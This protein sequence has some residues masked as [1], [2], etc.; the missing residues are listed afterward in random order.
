MPDWVA[1][2]SQSR[3]RSAG[4]RTLASAVLRVLAICIPAALLDA[5][6]TL[7]QAVEPSALAAGIPAEPLAEALEAFARLTGIQL[8]YVSDILREQ[9]SHAVPAG[10]GANEALARMLEGTGLEFQFLTPRSIRILAAVIGP[11]RGGAP[12]TPAGEELQEVIVTANR[13]EENLQNVPMTIQVLTGATLKKLNVTTFDDFVK[14]LPAVTAHGVGPGQNNIYVRGLGTAVPGIQGSGSLGTYP[15]VA[16]YLDEQS[17]Q[18][19][20]R[21]LDIYA[22]DLERIEILE[23]PQGTLFGAGAQAGVVRYITNKPKLDVTEVM[24]NAGY[25]A[26]AH[27][28]QSSNVDATLNIPLIADTLAVRGVIYNEKRGGYIDNIPATFARAATDLSIYYANA[29]GQV[30]TNSVVINNFGLVANHIN[31]VTYTGL[32]VEALYRFNEAWNA[33]FTQSY[34]NMQADGVFA[35]MA[36]NSLGEPQP[37]LSVQLYN[38]SYDKDRFEN[39]ALMINGRVGALKLLYAGSYLVRNVDQVQDYTNYARG[40]YTDF[41]QCVNPGPTPATAQCFTPSSTWRDVE[42]NT[43]QSHELRVST[44]GDERM[45]GIGGLFY[46]NYQI[47]DQVDWFYL[48]ALPYFHPIGPPTGYYTLN[49]STL[50]SNGARVAFNTPGAVFVPAPV[51]SNNPNIRPPSDGFFNDITRGYTQKAAYA[52]V[53][54]DL[55]PQELTL[56][57]GTRYFRTDSS[58]VG[59]SVGGFGCNQPSNIPTVP[60]PCVNHSNFT[61]I[62]AENLHRSLSGFRSRGSMSWKVTEDALLYYTWSQGYRAGGF[63]FNRGPAPAA[64]ISPLAPG[65]AP[66]QAQAREHGGWSPSLAFA[67]D[68]LTNNELGWKT[69]WRDRRIQWNGA[70]YQEDW[71]NAQLNVFVIGLIS[72]VILNGGNYRVR[73]IETSVVAHVTAGL[74]FEGGAAWNQSELVKQTPFL[75]RD[76]TPIDFS[77]LETSTGRKL[78]N[79]GGALGSQLAGAPPFQANI[80]ARYEFTFNRYDAFAQLDAVHQAKSLATTDRLSLDPQ[81]NSIAYDLPAFTVYGGALG[82]GKDGWRVQLYGENL[83]DKRAELYANRAEWYKAITVSRPRTIGLRFSY[84]FGGR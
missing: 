72:S 34:Q 44:P 68:N 76:G 6:A 57:A 45:R 52:S 74:T 78:S 17:A 53:D 29:A 32:R 70:I 19:P 36:A 11:P 31:P 38:P 60:D 62:N 66:Y 64:L 16:V 82:A 5:P 1:M 41:Y 4:N 9:R 59:S 37:D 55:I 49:G 79:P 22:A 48:S 42:R 46:E 39:T 24:V 69:M 84:A 47:Q 71:N 67:P 75:W 21:N 50:Q 61:N 73:G 27:G 43:H 51:T 54:F 33:I 7:A 81:G 26:T 10:L 35:E 23:G 14:Y 2:G 63:G 77:A 13:R 65:D 56:T 58:E 80:R 3:H 25:A 28:D 40:F 12:V 8:V 83:T 20:N 18:L 15:N 30:P